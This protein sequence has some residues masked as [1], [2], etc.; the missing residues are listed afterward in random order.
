MKSIIGN[1]EMTPVVHSLMKWDGTLDGWDA[2]SDL[3]PCVLKE[4]NVAVV[5][6]VSFKSECVAIDVMF[7]MNQITTKPIWIKRGSNL[8]KEFCKRVDQQSEGAEIVVIGFEWYS[9]NSLKA[10]T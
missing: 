5:E 6:N 4:A 3:E 1:F 7:I 2:K 8:A 9:D 10:M